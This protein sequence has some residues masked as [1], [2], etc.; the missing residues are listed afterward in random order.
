MHQHSYVND[1]KRR[2]E[3]MVESI[4]QLEQV[5]EKLVKHFVAKG[6]DLVHL[7]HQKG[8]DDAERRENTTSYNHHMPIEESLRRLEAR[9]ESVVNHIVEKD[10]DSTLIRDGF[11]KVGKAEE[12][13]SFAG[14]R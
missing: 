1:L 7:G 9:V 5:L 2:V 4:V 13:T 10:K 11:G 3:P 14:G 12:G 8:H 6:E